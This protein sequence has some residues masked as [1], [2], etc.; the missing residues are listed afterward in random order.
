MIA[1]TRNLASSNYGANLL[2]WSCSEATVSSGHGDWA[3]IMI[4]TVS[5]SHGVISERIP[6]CQ[7]TC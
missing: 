6:L 4:R 2:G 7:T 1:A 5:P 3:M